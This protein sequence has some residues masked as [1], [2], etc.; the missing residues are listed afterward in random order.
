[1]LTAGAA[2]AL[3]ACGSKAVIS[4]GSKD[5]TESLI[6]GEIV[7]AHLERQLPGVRIER[8]LGL[9]G[10]V[11]VQGAL[12]SGAIDLYAEDVGTILATVLKE[13]VPAEETVA[14]ERA[15]AQCQRL[16]QLSLLGPLGFHHKFVV[17]RTSGAGIK[18]D[19]LTAIG[20]SR[21][22]LKLGVAYDLFDRKDA[23]SALATKYRIS[24][25]E[26]PQRMGP[27]A[28]YLALKNGTI[29]LAAGYSTD[30][31]TNQEGFVVL[32]DDQE[33]FPAH[34]VC[35]LVRRQTLAAQSDL[36]R[37][38]GALA[39]SIKDDAMRKLN[40]EVDI[41]HRKP[42]DLAKEFLATAGL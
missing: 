26:L 20:D 1:M 38:L 8:K 2:L 21:A 33:L 23:F 10:T 12:Q 42:E 35:L 16:Y 13:D 41:K 27:R 36:E 3:C 32:K 34:E 39:G 28:M 6:L 7:A 17:S 15:R 30:S 25:R 40:Q 14:L 29:D 19:T 22:A 4:V 9:G 24:M 5:T 31:W 11:A 37:M 18:A